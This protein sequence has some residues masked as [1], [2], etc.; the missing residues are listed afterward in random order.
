[1]SLSWLLS[2]YNDI[3]IAYSNLPVFLNN[4]Q[5]LVIIAW[6]IKNREEKLFR[7]KEPHRFFR[8][9]ILVFV[10]QIPHI[11]IVSVFISILRLFQCRMGRD[12]M[13]KNGWAFVCKPR[14]RWMS[15]GS[16]IR[17]YCVSFLKLML[18]LSL[19]YF[20]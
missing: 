5:E 3:F 18:M 2:K 1:M 6:C 17:S 9:L 8:W 20:M 14:H 12:T 4:T 7:I 19:N 13:P 16:S 11:K 10:L 15:L